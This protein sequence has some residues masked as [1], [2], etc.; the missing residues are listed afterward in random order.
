MKW[1]VG[2]ICGFVGS[3]IF[4]T[5]MHKPG[6]PEMGRYAFGVTFTGIAHILASGE[7]KEIESLLPTVFAFGFGVAVARLL[8]PAD[9]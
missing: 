3:A 7:R 4:Y 6:F 9:E 2:F 8:L 5:P 1:L